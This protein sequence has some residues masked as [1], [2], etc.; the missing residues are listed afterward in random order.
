MLT[1]IIADDE[2]WI[3]QLIQNIVDWDK[4]GI[5]LI[6]TAKDGFTA[7]ELITT[8]HPDIV[9]TDIRMPGLNG[10]EIVKKTREL[11]LDTHFIIISGFKHF[12]YAHNALKYGVDDYLL[13]PIKQTELTKIL[14][15]ISN[16]LIDNSIKEN[17]HSLMRSKLIQSTRQLRRQFLEKAVFDNEALQ[18]MAELDCINEEYDFKFSKGCFQILIVKFDNKDEI[19]NIAEGYNEACEDKLSELM[20]EQLQDLCYDFQIVKENIYLLNYSE[21]LQD[22][23]KKALTLIFNDFKHFLEILNCRY[24][25]FGLGKQVEFFD[26]ISLS[27]ETAEIALDYRIDGSVGHMIDY[28]SREYDAYHAEKILTEPKIKELG[29]L[30]EV[31]DDEGIK[32]FVLYLFD[33]IKRNQNI[34]PRVFLELSEKITSICDELLEKSYSDAREAPVF[35]DMES[36]DFRDFKSIGEIRNALIYRITNNVKRIKEEINN[37]NKA[38]VRVAKKYIQENYN[39]KVS[40]NDIAALVNLNPV[41]FSLIFK[42]ETGINFSDY[43]INSK[44]DKSKELMKDLKYNIAEIAAMVGYNDSRHFSKLF[45]KKVG[46]SPMDYRKIH[47]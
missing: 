41:Y 27:G 34:D 2:K 38:P 13:K 14:R 29:N 9:I 23:I 33:S 26:K 5:K 1:A 42:K 37:Q 43:V 39:K 19:D 15:K 47:M 32:Q 22:Q 18:G 40:L 16:K 36:L 8:N 35:Q 3:C 30:V 20:T 12:E 6:G 31:L 17:E 24:V 45:K 25:T 44:L 4:L 11:E 10:I 21:K 28:S 46:I 7:L